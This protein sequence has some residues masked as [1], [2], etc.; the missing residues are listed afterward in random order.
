MTINEKTGQLIMSERKEQ[1][2][3]IRE[4]GEKIGIDYSQLGKIEKGK[5][6]ITISTLE[7]ILDFFG[8][9]ICFKKKKGL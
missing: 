6:N 9:E 5:I 8:Y 1:N 3:S 2:L 7:R 4:M